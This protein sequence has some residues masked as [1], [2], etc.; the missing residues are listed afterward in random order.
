MDIENA[1]DVL[2]AAYHY[3]DKLDF[4]EIKPIVY[5]NLIR[6]AL[7]IDKGKV[8]IQSKATVLEWNIILEQDTDSDND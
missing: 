7:D 3:L 1:R 8:S 6:L 2:Y 5:Q 4:D